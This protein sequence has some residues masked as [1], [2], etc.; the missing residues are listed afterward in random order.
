M[1]GI[2]LAIALAQQPDHSPKPCVVREVVAEG[3]RSDCHGWKP[4]K[5]EKMYAPTE[6]N[7]QLKV[8]DTFYF[9]WKE[10]RWIASLSP[11]AS[12]VLTSPICDPVKMTRY[13]LDN[14][15]EKRIAEAQQNR[16]K[17]EIEA[18]KLAEQMADNGDPEL[19]DR[20]LE[21]S[22]SELRLLEPPPVTTYVPISISLRIDTEVEVHER[23][24]YSYKRYRHF[25]PL[26]VHPYTWGRQ[27]YFRNSRRF[28]WP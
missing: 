19:L 13:Q 26:R 6:V 9:V 14:C 3:V 22:V 25:A 5:G 12:S 17:A 7:K 23:S 28:T 8:G 24:N 20:I 16:I 18:F 10:T 27:P 21:S 11:T 1:I 15:F 4:S 2:L